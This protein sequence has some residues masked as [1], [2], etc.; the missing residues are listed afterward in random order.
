MKIPMAEEERIAHYRLRERLGAGAMGEVWL[1][2][3]TRLHR[4]VALKRLKPAAAGDREA[5]ARL[6]R[7]ARVASTLTHP[8]VAV[9][10]DVGEDDADEKRGAWVAMEYV[11]GRTLA[12]LLKDGRMDAAQVL[13]VTEQV[14]EALADAHEHGIVHRDVKPGNVMLGERG[15]VKVLDFG[16]ARFAPPAH[17]DSLT[18]SG[19]H[20]ALD[21]MIVG[22]LSYMS[23]E[24]ARGH[25]VDARSDVFSLGVVLYEML[26]G[27]KPFDGRNMVELVEAI[28][29]REPQPPSAQDG[30][31]AGLG[32]LA[33]RML[34][35]DKE[36]R[37]TDMR[38][39]LEEL[40]KVRRGEPATATA[41]REHTVAVIGFANIT[42][43]PEDA[44]L[45]TGLAESVSA[46]LAGVPGFV[47]VSRER[48]LEVLRELGQ[49]AERDDPGVAVR[50]G[51]ELGV[52]GVVSGGYQSSG[53][54]IRVT[55]RLS[56]TASGRVMLHPQVDG[57]R[58]AIFELQDRLVAEIV[59][60]L[61][62]KLPAGGARPEETQSLAAYEAFSKGL[63]NLQAESPESIERAIVFFE[64]AIA[65]DPDYARA[66]MML[67]S[68]LDLK[69]DW[70]S[71]PELSERALVSLDRALALR[72]DSPDVW[73]N[74]GGVFVTLGREDEALAAY[75]LALSLNPL[76]FSGHSGLGRVHFILRG[77]F[78]AAVA[79]YE[80][81]LALNPR[82]G[83]A[84]L[85]LAHCATLLRDFPKAE[86]AARR[87][88]EL[89]QAFLSGRAGL[90]IV[91]AHMRLGHV[92]ALAGRPRDA[93]VEYGQELDFVR[94][95]DH[96]LRAR[97]F[98]ELQ[99][100]IG[101]AHLQLGESALGR[102]ALDLAV[103]SL[104][105]RMRSGAI[106]TMSPYY[107]AC[108]YALRGEAEPA[109]ECLERAARS[110]P[111]LTAARA[112]IEPALESLRDEPRF[113]ALL[114]PAAA[115]RAGG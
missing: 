96:A 75:E 48:I 115:A 35:K 32:V 71:A 99:Q 17:E 44:W 89:Q 76:D 50:V 77:D 91:G 1:A 109:L 23:P 46:G 9:V 49:S 52:R 27:R 94:K 97:I 74:R 102:A 69:G 40:E 73:R 56:E 72:P 88:L 30:L 101:E 65:L 80:R 3:D 5:E 93:L 26:T 53:D 110:R 31:A 106:D 104:D 22:T 42:G 55:A 47:V 84:A 12:E 107:G 68:T 45:A 7:E 58:E 24:Q 62:E 103:E 54:R 82:A 105:R 28:M 98:I 11:K 90:V 81:A 2:E 79:A 39:V 113:Q 60:G 33:L 37:P 78:A 43:R 63:I 4:M 83:W 25:A 6:V 67:G 86:T 51:R 111:R 57:A 66:H 18:W 19:R 114:Q 36:R 92:A 21:G 70:L 20:G 59:H 108:A 15:L 87:A 100:R 95:V 29:S 13:K 61:R 64:R 85:Q 34:E 38:E 14:A 10:Y 8:N 112:A 16:L 41:A